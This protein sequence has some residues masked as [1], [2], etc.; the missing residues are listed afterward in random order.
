MKTGLFTHLD[1]GQ[2]HPDYALGT[3]DLSSQP[4]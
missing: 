1:P 4:V 2:W 3:S